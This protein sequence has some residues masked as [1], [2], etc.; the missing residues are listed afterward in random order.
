M[1]GLS[2][3][4]RR[5][6]LAAW[7][8][9]WLFAVPVAV[10]LAPTAFH[11]VRMPD[12]YKAAT[13]VSVRPVSAERVGG[14]LPVAQDW[15]REQLLGTARDRVLAAGNVSA[16]IPVLWPKGNPTDPYTIEQARGR[17]LY[18]QL[19]DTRFAISLEDRAPARAA[20]AVNTLV[21]AFIASERA[22]R[23][24]VATRRREF[25]E[26]ELTTARAAYEAAADAKEAFRRAH[27]DTMP[28]DRDRLVSDLH[29]IEQEARER[30]AEAQRN[31][32]MVPEIDKWMK[33]ALPGPGTDPGRTSLSAD[34]QM[35]QLK[36]A[37]GQAALDQ[38][39]RQLA[40]LRAKYTDAYDRVQVAVAQVRALEKEVERARGELAEAK[41]RADADTSSRKRADNQ[42]LM[43][44][45]KTFRDSL[46]AE[47]AASRRTAEELR[48]KAQGISGRLALIPA[49]ADAL[50]PVESAL[51]TAKDAFQRIEKEARDARVAE[52]SYRRLSAGETIGFSVETPAVAPTKPSGPSRTRWLATAVLLGVGI[53]YGL[54]V[55]RRRYVD[56]DLVAGPGDLADLVPGALVVSVPLLG[57]GPTRTRARWPDLV[58]G[59]LV[60]ICLVATVFAL[61]CHRGVFAPPD[62]FRPW[63]AGRAS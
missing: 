21:E 13:V 62:W 1:T 23:L 43:G 3:L 31:R 27:P 11:V 50:R 59:P 16:M 6:A 30:E 42:E 41:G 18:D 54:H 4:V 14:A 57:A 2:H 15:Q 48:A 28:D 38:A 47:E 32:L 39:S 53:G 5:A 56:E 44:S 19:G 25:L 36:L 63:L 29:R 9:R 7:E 17:V 20:E 12:V 24:A 45:L 35:A 40:E 49:T 61:G 46:L 33:A 22:S 51:E 26:A 60:A 37:S 10:L 8:R 55:L 58:F 52:D 34:E